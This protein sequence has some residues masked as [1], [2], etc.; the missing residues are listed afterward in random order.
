MA[1]NVLKNILVSFL[2]PDLNQSID[3]NKSNSVYNN[4][5]EMNANQSRFQGKK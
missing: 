3:L 5:V 1:C 4:N 2:N